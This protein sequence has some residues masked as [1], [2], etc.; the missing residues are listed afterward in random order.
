MIACMPSQQRMGV[1]V[2]RQV[3][4]LIA[5]RALDAMPEWPAP[6]RIAV[7]RARL[8]DTR[9]ALSAVASRGAAAEGTAAAAQDAFLIGLHLLESHLSAEVAEL[10]RGDGPAA[11]RHA[12][13]ANAAATVITRGL[14]RAATM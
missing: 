8:V 14:E 5:P 7:T 6:R 4:P 1:R 2:L 12:R 11:D 10:R 9:V 13:R 3:K